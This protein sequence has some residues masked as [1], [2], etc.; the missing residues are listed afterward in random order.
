MVWLLFVTVCVAKAIKFTNLAHEL[1]EKGMILSALPSLVLNN[2][3]GK[4][5]VP[6]SHEIEHLLPNRTRDSALLD[7]ANEGA[8]LR[9][10][11]R[12]LFD[13]LAQ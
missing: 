7:K 10:A 3:V 1:F 5:R 12:A 6:T 11:D 2:V 13:G 9:W 4:P 8:K